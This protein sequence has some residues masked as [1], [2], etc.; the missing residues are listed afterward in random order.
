MSA[1]RF[2]RSALVNGWAVGIAVFAL[3]VWFFGPV[4]LLVGGLGVGGYLVYT[5]FRNGGRWQWPLVAAG[6]LVAL[7]VSLP[8][9]NQ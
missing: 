6:A 8:M 3:L 9:L 5:G 1:P 7:L 2:S 4:L